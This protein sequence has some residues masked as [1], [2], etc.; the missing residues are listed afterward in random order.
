MWDHI[1]SWR[2]FI[3]GGWNYVLL[4]ARQPTDHHTENSS[5]CKEIINKSSWVPSGK[6]T[7]IW[8]IHENPHFSYVKIPEGMP[9]T[10]N[11]A[12]ASLR[13][14]GLCSPS[15][16]R[17]EVGT[18]GRLLEPHVAASGVQVESCSKST[19]YPLVNGD[20][21]TNLWWFY[22]GLMVI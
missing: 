13:C 21:T 10:G 4:M 20:L 6:P 17:E 14:Q 18:W 9:F 1:I 5:L 15:A 2:C 16:G 12:P 22:G 3:L 8:K 7:Q 19:G 11:F